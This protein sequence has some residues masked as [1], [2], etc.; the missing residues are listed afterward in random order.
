MFLN[1]TF[2]L[3]VIFLRAESTNGAVPWRRRMLLP[4]P[5]NYERPLSRLSLPSRAHPSRRLPTPPPLS[6]PRPTPLKSSPRHRPPSAPLKSATTTTNTTA[7]TIVL[8][9]PPLILLLKYYA[10]ATVYYHTCSL[11]SSSSSLSVE[12]LIAN[13]KA[14]TAGG[15]LGSERGRESA[16]TAVGVKNTRSLVPRG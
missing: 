6:L 4:S 16:G 2:F 5:P 8:R 11:P 1:F 3:Y 13:G 15:G 9:Q 10:A 14:G 7:L 12:V